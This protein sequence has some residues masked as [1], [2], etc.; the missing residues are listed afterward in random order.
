MWQ[1]CFDLATR[2]SASTSQHQ[3][4]A[5]EG[6]QQ[7][8]GTTSDQTRLGTSATTRGMEVSP[9]AAHPQAG[10]LIDQPSTSSAAPVLDTSS[11]CR[12][13]A[14]DGC[15]QPERMGSGQQHPG[16]RSAPPGLGV[17][18]LPF[19][20]QEE[21]WNPES[22]SLDHPG[23]SSTTVSTT[24]AAPSGCLQ[25]SKKSLS[26]KQRKD[27]ASVQECPESVESSSAAPAVGDSGARA[28]LQEE[29]SKN[30]DEDKKDGKG[31]PQTRKVNNGDI[32][33]IRSDVSTLQIVLPDKLTSTLQEGL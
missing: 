23:T 1:N 19:N 6:C 4:I 14:V 25:R 30:G 5:G 10:S 12:A 20:V 9:S 29:G 26:R 31:G 8:L 17:D 27:Q 15:Q 24:S 18:A 33:F 21:M 22:K 3:A 11:L 2:S 28:S 13:I 16:S 7:P 32:F